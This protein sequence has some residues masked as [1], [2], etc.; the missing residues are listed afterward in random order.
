MISEELKKR[1]ESIIEI[2]NIQWSSIDAVA[3]KD[4][5]IL[6]PIKGIAFEEYMKKII[7]QADESVDMKDGV[8]D[9]DVDFMLMALLCR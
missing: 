5:N 2:H 6:R 7:K 3:K 1:F 4:A 9:S 8:G